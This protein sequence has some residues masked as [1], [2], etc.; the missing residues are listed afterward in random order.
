MNKK[1]KPMLLTTTICLILSACGS[2][3][4]NDTT[5]IEPTVPTTPTT[6]TTNQ[7]PQ[8]YPDIAT[9][10]QGETITIDALANDT[11]PENDTL[12]ITSAEGLIIDGNI[13]SYT[14]PIDEVGDKVFNYTI[15]DSALE[16]SSTITITI[17]DKADENVAISRGEYAG[18]ET[19]ATCHQQ[20]YDDWEESRHASMLRKLY[21]DGNTITAPWGTEDEP[22]TFTD[23]G[24]HKYTSYM[25]GDKYWV[26]LHDAIDSSNDLDFQ[27]D[28]VGYKTTQMF[29]S[30]DEANQNY[31]TMPFI[32][33]DWEDSN[34]KQPSPENQWTPLTSGIFFFNSDGSLFT[35]DKLELSKRAFGY[36][37]LCIECHTTGYEVTSWE[38]KDTAF[39][40][41]VIPIDNTSKTVEFGIACE[42]CHGPGAEHARTMS[43]DDIIQPTKDLTGEQAGDECNVCHIAPISLNSPAAIQ[44]GYGYKFNADNPLGHGMFPNPGD[45]LDEFQGS[46]SDNVSYWPGTTIRRHIR[47]H[48][49]ELEESKHGEYGMSCVTCHDPH[50][51]KLKFNGDED[52]DALCIS[53]HAEKD[54]D[55]HKL[56]SHNQVDVKCADCHMPWMKHAGGR[57]HRYDG[58]SHSWDLLTPTDSLKG[59]DELRPYTEVGADPDAQLTKDWESIQAIKDLC[60]DN[61]NYPINVVGCVKFDIMP[62]ACSSCHTDEFPTPGVF[63]DEERAK[64]VE[65]EKRLE[66]FKILSDIND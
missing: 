30:W 16:S 25:K 7:S 21:S 6:P 22:F 52:S 41:R 46:S 11:D 60:Y 36:T 39:G 1:I 54:S 38:I 5:V 62:N 20:K 24:N 34:P 37:N 66:A 33:W 31:I 2:D 15:S 29:L 58:T 35:G 56:A 10:T 26:T 63:T 51:Q 23:S 48:A 13:I 14:A 47:T 28:V 65:G 55:D 12:S 8:A 59:F 17:L 40:N 18:A 3:N 53:C 9:V 27:I 61:F 49:L 19:C 44:K 43:P 45:N 64:L 57:G 32:Y 4:N 50:S 42:K